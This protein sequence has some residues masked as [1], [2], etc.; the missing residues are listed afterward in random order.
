MLLQ[1]GYSKFKTRDGGKLYGPSVT[2]LGK[3]LHL[4]RAQRTAIEALAYSKNFCARYERLKNAQKEIPG[5]Q[6]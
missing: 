4:K 5:D 6:G 2:S 3:T 1:P